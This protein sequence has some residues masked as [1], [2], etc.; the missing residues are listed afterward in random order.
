MKY[1]LDTNTCIRYMNGSSQRV[2]D[3]LNAL[4][5]GDAVVCSVVKA[6]LFFGAL[7][8]QNPIKTMAGQRQ[9]LSLFVS[10][11]FDDAAAEYYAQIRAELSQKGTPIGSNDLLIA[12]ISLANGLTLVTHNTREFGRITRLKIEDWETD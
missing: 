6:E 7:R 10:L 9:F 4:D 1:L 8:S 12:A 3:N 5:K 2:A 11:P